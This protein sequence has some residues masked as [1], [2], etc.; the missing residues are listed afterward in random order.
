MTIGLAIILGL[1]FGFVLQ[2]V[3]AANPQRII[4]MLRLRDFHLMKAILMGIGLSSLIL[5]ILLALGVIP[6]SHLS[7]KSSHIGVIAGGAILGLGWAIAGFCPG[8][9]VVA[10]G[11]GR[12]D[13]IAFILGGLFGAFLYMMAYRF[14]KDSILFG[15]LG[16]KSTLAETGN[17]SYTALF[18]GVSPL[19]VVGTIALILIFIACI[20]PKTTQHSAD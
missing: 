8:T 12:R 19:L 18:A 2:K 20:L 10:A 17:S 16:G 13:A 6:A 7:V 5:F 11:A 14:I 1:L 9:G 15:D 3:G 4:D